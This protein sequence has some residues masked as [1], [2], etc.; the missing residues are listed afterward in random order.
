M[1]F[2]I[3][4]YCVDTSHPETLATP[5]VGVKSPHKILIVVVLPAPLGPRKPND[6]TFVD[7]EAYVIDSHEIA[8][9]S[10]EIFSKYCYF[11]IALVQ[12]FRLFISVR[13]TEEMRRSA[14]SAVK[15][16]WIHLF[17]SWF[18]LWGSAKEKRP[19]W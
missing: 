1:C 14:F 3:S 5:E 15:S 7:L 11:P 9:N 8:E 18:R 6:F 16:P 2:L 13:F 12:P 17:L 4:S 19:L 10:C